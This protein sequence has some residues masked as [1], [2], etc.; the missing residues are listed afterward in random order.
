MFFW[1]R[2]RVYR[3]NLSAQ[4]ARQD[5]IVGYGK[6]LLAFLVVACLAIVRLPE[7]MA[8]IRPDFA[9]L[10]CL[11]FCIHRNNNFSL[12]ICWLLGFITDLYASDVFLQH[13]LLFL[14]AA[15]YI[16]RNIESIRRQDFLSQ[17]L[18]VFSVVLVLGFLESVL[19][20]ILVDT[21]VDLSFFLSALVSVLVWPIF[22]ALMDKWVL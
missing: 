7:W 6:W 18:V 16:K 3:M 4:V 9:L 13:A 12:E 21:S 17:L 5:S 14:L 22:S 8:I 11:F 10:F 2:Q 1:F 19:L 15:Y 20:L